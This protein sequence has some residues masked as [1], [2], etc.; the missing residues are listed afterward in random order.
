MKLYYTL[1]IIVLILLIVWHVRWF[2]ASRVERPD[3]I[4]ESQKKNIKIVTLPSR[5]SAS[6]QVAW[7]PIDAPSK[8]FGLLAG[9]IF[10]D[11]TKQSSIQM[12]APV[13][14]TAV[15]SEKIAMTAP[16]IAEKTDT[17][18]TKVSFLMPSSWTLET[19]PVPNN[20]NITIQEESPKKIAVWTFSGYAQAK[21]VEK[22]WKSFQE[23][24]E[25]QSIQWT[26]SYTIAQYNDPGTPPWMRRNELRVSLE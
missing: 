17:N 6:V 18:L 16:V 20:K 15:A 13:T 8:A 1:C 12:T 26:W 3:M 14:S 21:K 5:I 22:E 24:L 7:D 11:N 9:F 19:L 2:Y 4:V 25:N 23:E 10:G